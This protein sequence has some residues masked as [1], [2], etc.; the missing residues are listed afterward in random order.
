MS[1][2]PGETLPFLLAH[3]FRSTFVYF[4]FEFRIE[5]WTE[6]TVS[7]ILDSLSTGESGEL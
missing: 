5:E 3:E 6:W 2:P 4:C 1:A 7:L